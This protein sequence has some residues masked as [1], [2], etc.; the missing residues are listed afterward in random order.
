MADKEDKKKKKKKR[1]KKDKEQKED[2]V[3][4]LKIAYA[5]LDNKKSFM[6]QF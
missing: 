6:A 4:Q 5:T 2:F 1:D 3:K